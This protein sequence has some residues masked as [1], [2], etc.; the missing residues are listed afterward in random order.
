MRILGNAAWFVGTFSQDVTKTEAVK[1]QNRFIRW[2]REVE[3]RKVE[4]AAVWEVTKTNRLHLN[5]VLAPWM[6][7]SQQE[8]SRRWHQ[9]GGGKVVWIERVDYGIEL[10]LSKQYQKLSNYMAKFEQLCEEGRGINYS[11]GWPKVGVLGLGHRRGHIEWTWLRNDY[12][13]AEIF[14]QEAEAGIW[15]EVRPGEYSLCGEQEPC[16]CFDF[17]DCPHR[18]RDATSNLLPGGVAGSTP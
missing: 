18:A 5:L 14:E 11:K 10:E 9:Y 2:L 1:T 15:Q 12:D 13:E 8:L 7:C 4:Y 16:N 3:G 6:Y 17:V